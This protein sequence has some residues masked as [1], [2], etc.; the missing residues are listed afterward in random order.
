[1]PI[2]TCCKQVR[3][4]SGSGIIYC[5]SRRQVDELA[6]RLAADGESVL[7]YHAGLNDDTRR[8]HQN[9]LHSR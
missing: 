6:Q 2:G 5:L 8:D 7:P 3:Q 1:M 9:P 4:H